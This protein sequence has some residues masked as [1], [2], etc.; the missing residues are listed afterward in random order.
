MKASI[1]GRIA[2]IKT[3]SNIPAVLYNEIAIIG[4]IKREISI[5][6]SKIPI[7]VPINSFSNTAEAYTKLK[8]NV[9]VSPIQKRP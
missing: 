8:R 9:I 4:P 6:E 2:K 3:G 7:D 1:A 5:S